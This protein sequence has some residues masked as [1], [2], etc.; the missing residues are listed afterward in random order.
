MN[1]RKSTTEA[2]T[3]TFFFQNKITEGVFCDAVYHFTKACL[4]YEGL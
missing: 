2:R 1:N 4:I 3:E